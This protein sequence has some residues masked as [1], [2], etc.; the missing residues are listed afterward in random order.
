M[1]FV[2]IALIIAVI[3]LVL[4]A[5]KQTGVLE[6]ITDIKSLQEWIA[7]FGAWG[8]IVFVAAF[9]FACVFLLPGSAFT[10]VAGIVF[11]PIKGGVLALFSATLGAVVAFIVAR[12]LLRNT[13]MKKFGDNPIFK[14]NR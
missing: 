7:G 12:F 1:K 9:V 14:K 5:A 2:K 8:Y 13:I 4:F 10:I 11:G 6:I 3:A